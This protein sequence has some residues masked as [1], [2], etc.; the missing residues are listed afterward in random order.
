MANTVSYIYEILDR[1]SAPLRKISNNTK[2]FANAAKHAQKS[3]QGLSRKMQGMADRASSLQGALGGLGLGAALKHVVNVSSD[4]EDAMSDIGRVTNISAAGLLAFED[5]LE[6]ISEKLGKSKRGLAEMAFEGGKLGV[7]IAKM[8]EFLMMT[9]RTAIAFDMLDQEAGRAIGSI[10]AKMGL[11]PE[12]TQRLLD[13]VNFLADSTSANGAN[14]INIV[15]RLAGTFSLLEVPPEASAALAGFAD[16]LEVTAELG[17]SG[18]SMMI[19]QMRKMPGMTT[20]LMSDPLGVIQGQLEKMADMGPE[21]RTRYIEKVFGAEASRFVEKAVANI[22]LYG[23]TVETAMSTEAAGSMQRELENQM[24]RSSKVFEILGQTV[25]NTF[26]TIGDVIKPFA[27]SISKAI[28]PVLVAVREFAKNNPNVVKF[29]A[30]IAALVVVFTGVAVAVG[31]LMAAMAPLVG[32]IAAFALPIVA[33]VALIAG[34]TIAFQQWQESGHPIIEML[35]GIGEDI[36]AIFSPFGELLGIVGDAGEGFGGLT[37][38]IDKLGFAVMAA[39]TPVR[40]L[41]K[42]LRGVVEVSSAVLAGDFSSAWEAIKSTGGELFN[43]GK[44]GVQSYG[45]AFGMDNASAVA[46]RRGVEQKQKVSGE[47]VV[48]ASSGSKIESAGIELNGGANLAY[49]R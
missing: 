30:A 24:G 26:D 21:L 13:S 7:P 35:R 3:V 47:I 15:E 49:G 39:M 17:A 34:L 29:G 44:E 41:L 46:D 43:I 8:E 1:Y 27:V 32:F 12:E 16:Q 18:L 11:I 10:Q 9:S 40:L 4:M 38:F 25:V 14:M 42:T 36:A 2:A 19:R 28:T 31:M 23:K 37:G 5:S 20:K 33:A 48:T 45:A 6:G 22:E